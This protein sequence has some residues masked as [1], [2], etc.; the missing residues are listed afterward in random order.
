MPSSRGFLRPILAYAITVSGI[1]AATL[2]DGHR[3]WSLGTLRYLPEAGRWAVIVFLVVAPV[4]LIWR[5]RLIEPKSQSKSTGGMSTP[6][7]LGGLSL[8]LIACFVLFPNTTHFNGDG[9][10]QMGRLEIH[11]PLAKLRDYGEQLIHV[12][13]YH[14]LEGKVIDPAG[15]AY[16]IISIAAGVF[17]CLT[18]WLSTLWL[19]KDRAFR[20]LFFL[21]MASGGY[22]LL[23]FGYVENYSVLCLAITMTA[24]TGILA[25]RGKLSPLWVL[26][27]T[28]ITCFLHVIGSFLWPGT[29]YVLIR[30]T[31]LGARIRKL[32]PRHR[33][34]LG[35]A[36]FLGGTLVF[37][38]LYSTNLFF[39]LAF[40]PLWPRLTTVEGYTLFSANH[41][42]DYFS[43]LVCLCPGI[44]VL[45][46]HLFSV[47]RRI[48]WKRPEMLY[49]AILSL[50][51]CF[52]AFV[53]DPK[54]GMA[55][56]WDL[57]S[58]P[59]IAIM[60]TLTYPLIRM[61]GEKKSTRVALGLSII[62]CF[63]LLGARTAVLNIPEAGVTQVLDYFQLDRIRSRTGVIILIH[64]Y[65]DSGDTAA[66]DRLTRYRLSTYPEESLSRKAEALIVAKR[67]GEAFQLARRV[68]QLNAHDP[69][70]WIHLGRCYIAAGKAD[71]AIYYLR[72]ANAL[73]PHGMITLSEL[74]RAYLLKQEYETAAGFFRASIDIDTTSCNPYWGLA[75][76]SRATLD[77]EGYESRTVEASRR[78][79]APGWLHKSLGDTYAE[80]ADRGGAMLQYRQA[81]DKGLDS[82]QT[83]EVQELMLRLETK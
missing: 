61:G 7:I 46:V 16:K 23:F 24:L 45:S 11:N 35:L 77:E 66:A 80:K 62:L 15:T 37:L 81:L 74:G 42:I 19:I 56:D 1:L 5:A 33:Y 52:F 51:A 54:L 13:A 82:L 65:R 14:W 27:C 58:F 10:L 44:G 59:G 30:R 76:C 38:W 12:S 50:T 60:L 69:A 22:M 39:R 78:S 47:R 32:G 34:A 17:F 26:V 49:L 6:L 25:I 40:L 55:R 36:T 21:A 31:E 63:G 3:F 83:I 43:L 28:V 8:L 9:Y 68:V 57:F 48:Q 71:S 20:I 67:Y 53:L 41:L 29:L 2:A 79:D 64:Y 18:L 72:T 4:L 73:N 75:L 70:G